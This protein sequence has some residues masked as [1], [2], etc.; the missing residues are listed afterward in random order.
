MKHT[1]NFCS[2]LRNAKIEIWSREMSFESSDQIVIEWLNEEKTN[3]N[4]IF[5]RGKS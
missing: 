3:N 1:W 4:K 2:E 5:L